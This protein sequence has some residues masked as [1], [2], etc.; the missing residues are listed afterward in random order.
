MVQRTV[1]RGSSEL[2]EFY[3]CGRSLPGAELLLCLHLLWGP[4]APFQ[5]VAVFARRWVC[6]C[7][8]V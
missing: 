7:E 8:G 2:S 3:L 5:A 4:A 1:L 6:A